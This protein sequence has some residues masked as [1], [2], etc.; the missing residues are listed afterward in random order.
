ML[1]KKRQYERLSRSIYSSE[2]YNK[3][4]H[5]LLES[6]KQGYLT[7]TEWAKQNYQLLCLRTLY[8]QAK[9]REQ[10]DIDLDSQ[11]VRRARSKSAYNQWKEAKSEGNSE[12]RHDHTNTSHSQQTTEGIS[13]LSNNSVSIL[14]SNT[15]DENN[16]TLADTSLRMSISTSA[17]SEIQRTL[18]NQPISSSKT[19]SAIENGLYMLDE[20]RWSLQAMLKRVVG[21]AEP[22][23]PPPKV[24][25]RKQSPMTNISSDSGFESGL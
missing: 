1:D 21:L 20:Q 10:Q 7:H 17:D 5:E 23:P 15:I 19:T 16:T 14:M 3:R 2:Y 6:Y 9:R 12:R 4:W 18:I 8:I 11:D 22:L 13:F 24:V 25:K